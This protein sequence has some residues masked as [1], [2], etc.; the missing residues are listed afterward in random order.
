MCVDGAVRNRDRHKNLAAGHIGHFPGFGY[1]FAVFHGKS[2]NNRC[3]SRCP[4]KFYRNRIAR[5]KNPGQQGRFGYGNKIVSVKG[6]IVYRPVS[7]GIQN[8]FPVRGNMER[9]TCRIIGE[10]NFSR[11]F[12]VSEQ[13]AVQRTGEELGGLN[14]VNVGSGNV[15]EV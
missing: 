10:R 1:S 9:V 15:H 13:R 6:T 3:I 8:R 5:K 4:E 14:T 7:A 12:A 2:Q 11:Q